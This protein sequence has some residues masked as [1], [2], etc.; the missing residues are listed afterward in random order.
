[1]HDILSETE[2]N[3]IVVT[4][5]LKEIKRLKGTAMLSQ[6]IVSTDGKVYEVVSEHTNELTT[7]QI[8]NRV[9]VLEAELNALKK[10]LE[11]KTEP[12]STSVYTADPATIVVPANTTTTEQ[13]SPQ[14]PV[15]PVAP[16]QETPQP[17]VL[18]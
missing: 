7:E 3:K 1:M 5:L 9:D 10:L 18:Q 15:M 11:P 16:V 12:T 4:N 2:A 6:I 13:V 14:P 17:L 8:Q